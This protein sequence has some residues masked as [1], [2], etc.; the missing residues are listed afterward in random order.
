MLNK[1][2]LIGNL[3]ADP[4][5]RYTP[6]GTKV[7]SFRIATS[8]TFKDKEGEKQTATEWHNIVTFGKLADICGEYLTKG[9]QVY[10]EGRVHYRSWDDKEGNKRYATDI[11]AAVMK[12]LGPKDR[13]GG[14]SAAGEAPDDDVPF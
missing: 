6:N 13:Q 10:I 11:H 9:R 12:M 5:V 8:E 4:E 1:L 3:G 2:L 14:Q 7:A